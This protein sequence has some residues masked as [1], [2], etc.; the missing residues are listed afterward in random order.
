MKRWLLILLV[1]ILPGG[2]ILALV[3]FGNWKKF[4]NSAAELL[5]RPIPYPNL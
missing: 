5:G 2:L 1:V 3:A 4:A